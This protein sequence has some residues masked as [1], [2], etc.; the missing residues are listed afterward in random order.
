M[1]P[2]HQD[3]KLPYKDPKDGVEYFFRVLT[4]ENETKYNAIVLRYTKGLPVEDILVVEDEL[5]NFLLV[6]W[7]SPV[8]FPEDGKPSRYFR[9]AAKDALINKA[10]ELNRLAEDEVKN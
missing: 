5:F 7:C 10:I 3:E 9:H 2:I 8:A 4:G 1:I 6:G